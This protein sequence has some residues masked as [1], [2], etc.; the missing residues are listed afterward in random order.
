MKYEDI[1]TFDEKFS[2][3]ITTAERLLRKFPVHENHVPIST[4]LK[5]KEVKM[6]L[7]AATKIVQIGPNSDTRK[8]VTIQSIVNLFVGLTF[9]CIERFHPETFKTSQKPNRF[10]I[11]NFL[12][13]MREKQC[14]C[15]R[16]GIVITD[17]MFGA[18]GFESDHVEEN[19][20]ERSNENFMI[21]K[22]KFA[23]E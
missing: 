20:H 2:S 16:C 5:E 18:I 7:H 11:E 23:D 1:T 22:L 21:S 9:G 3:A 14:A 10:V 6:L 19:Y 4:I 12:Y 8:T 17:T 13:L 15:A